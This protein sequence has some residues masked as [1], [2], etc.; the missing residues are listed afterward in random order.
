[1]KLSKTVKR[2]QEKGFVDTAK[3]YGRR[4]TGKQS[5]KP[6]QAEQPQQP[7][8]NLKVYKILLLTNRD[9]DNV[10]D[11]VIEASDIALVSTIMQNLNIPAKQYK[12]SSRAASI[13]S[14]AY[15]ASKNPELLATAKKAIGECDMVIFGGAPMFNYLYQNFYERTAVTLEL[16]QALEKPVIL[17]AIGVERYDE[18]NRKCQRLKKTLNFD[19]VKQITTRDGMD[20]LEKYKE[21][22]QL[23]IGKVSD[24]AV[25]TSTVFR[26]YRNRPQ[27][28]AKKKIG[29]FV[30]RANG[31][32]D[33]RIDF[34]REDSVAMW[35]E[36]IAELESKGYD[37]ELVTSGHF[38]DE[39][40]L[41]YMI[42]H[43][44]INPKK[45]VFN[46]NSPERLIQKISSYSAVVSCR[47]HPSIIS[48]S[49]DVPSVGIKW[50]SKVPGFYNSIGYGNRV[51]DITKASAADIVQAVEVAM[52]Q[53]IQKDQQYLSTVYTT[54]FQGIKNIICPE[55]PIEAYDYDQILTHIPAYK[56]TSQTEQEEKLKRKFRRTYNN[57]NE[58]FDKIEQ[59]K[60]TIE[61]LKAENEKLKREA[62]EK[63]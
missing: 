43:C 2:I 8:K 6:Q 50:N 34:T 28:D 23:M 51:I 4:I 37:Y 63:N 36:M 38:G 59:L 35:K 45:C 7:S 61:N 32:V 40:F 16:A 15:L 46:M 11:Q 52:E 44:G 53:G 1:M 55:K 19:C 30:L 25:F 48:F 10:G 58:R 18:D 31:F 42:R 62:E 26:N 29:L 22:P 57:C 49:L 14:Q 41:D 54:L 12:I 9:S 33:N 60:Q 56:G 13:V 5:V 3:Y 17:S 21:N 27:A 20:L 39:A 47:L 24:P